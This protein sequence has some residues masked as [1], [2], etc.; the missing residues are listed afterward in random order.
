MLTSNFK[1][2]DANQIATDRQVYGVACH[3]AAIHAKSPSERY[4]LT[5]VFN[6]VVK[7]YYSDADSFM[8]HGDVSEFREWECVPEQFLLL[9]ANKKPKVKAKPKAEAKP[10]PV[11]KKAKPKAA[12]TKE[13]LTSRVDSLEAKMDKIL[14]ILSA[15]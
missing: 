10:K 4:G 14:E 2:I 15:K 8:T 12:A 5:K 6:A 3:F 9:V 7:K 13:T 11:A 1:N